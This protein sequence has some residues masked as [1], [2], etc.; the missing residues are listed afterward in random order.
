M[1]IEEFVNIGNL[2]VP[3]FSKTIYKSIFSFIDTSMRGTFNEYALQQFFEKTWTGKAQEFCEACEKYM[4]NNTIEETS[5][6]K[7][8][9]FFKASNIN[10]FFFFCARGE[11]ILTRATN[12][13]DRH[14]F[15]NSCKFHYDFGQI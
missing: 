14:T 15:S 12:V 4:K 5:K 10:C 8:K 6:N 3:H 1:T 7:K 13:L 2:V 11:K 9:S